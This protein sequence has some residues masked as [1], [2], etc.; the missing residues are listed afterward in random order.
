MGKNPKFGPTE[1]GW[2]AKEDGLKS[3]NA[4][5]QTHIKIQFYNRKKVTSF[6][7]WTFWPSAPISLSPT[8]HGSFFDVVFQNVGQGFSSDWPEWWFLLAHLMIV[9][10]A[11]PGL[12]CIMFWEYFGTRYPPPPSWHPRM[13]RGKTTQKRHIWGQFWPRVIYIHPI[14]YKLYFEK[15]F[16]RVLATFDLF[17]SRFCCWY[18][19][20]WLAE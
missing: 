18:I 19:N 7:F 3:K 8:T 12:I 17:S 14:L 16:E 20:T 2:F 11:T 4:R 10:N 5:K 9:L 13:T 6:D 15:Y 1:N